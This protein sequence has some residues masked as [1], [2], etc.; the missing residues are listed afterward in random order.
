MSSDIISNETS[1]SATPSASTG[2]AVSGRYRGTHFPWSDKLQKTARKVWGFH[3]FRPLQLPILNAV[4]SNETVFIMMPSL[5]GKS[6]CY[7]LPA[8]LQPGV[9]LVLSPYY[10]LIYDQFLDLARLGIKPILLTNSGTFSDLA[11]SRSRF[12]QLIKKNLPKRRKLKVKSESPHVPS[13]LVY[14]TLETFGKKLSGVTFLKKLYNLG[15]LNRIVIDECQ[16]ASEQTWDTL[17]GQLAAAEDLYQ[18]SKDVPFTFLTSACSLSAMYEILYKYELPGISARISV[19]PLGH[20]SEEVFHVGSV[21]GEYRRDI[22]L[23]TAPL[24]RPNLAYHVVRRPEE[25]EAARQ[26][27]IQW[28]Q[29]YHTGQCGLIFCHLRDETEFLA[30]QLSENNIRAEPYHGQMHH[31]RRQGAHRRWR[32]EETHVLVSTVAFGRGIAHPHV[33]FVIHP[34]LSCTLESYYYESGRAG[35]DGAPA[36]CV[37]FHQMQDAKTLARWYGG[38]NYAPYSSLSGPLAF[39]DNVSRC[40]QLSLDDYL[41][42]QTHSFYIN[43]PHFAD[44]VWSY[45]QYITE[46]RTKGLDFLGNFPPEH[47]DRV[48]QPLEPASQKPP[49]GVDTSSP[50]GR[51][52]ICTQRPHYETVDVCEDVKSICVVFR[53]IEAVNTSGITPLILYKAWCKK[54]TKHPEIATAVE[55]N[56][57][58]LAPLQT[59]NRSEC[60]DFLF[61]CIGQ[62]YFTMYT[63]STSYKTIAYISIGSKGQPFVDEFFRRRA[64]IESGEELIKME[65][66]QNPTILYRYC[67]SGENSNTPPE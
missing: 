24:L 17:R 49:L 12:L 67:P 15:V 29:T 64:R 41:V 25:S 57:I 40:R 3:E 43:Q 2:G 19:D 10:A 50:C 8:L 53:L 36:D 47:I 13:Y 48:T 18:Y 20:Y 5:G 14:M 61:W 45:N 28:I 42:G 59:M 34:T 27:L 51:C 16:S 55:R 22:I 56:L 46:Y 38:Q 33:R 66:V 52:D 31:D 23:F 32:E 9:T 39:V 26:Q 54:Y 4:M 65:S 37:I 44:F 35:G 21:S 58:R 30:R 60:Q 1:Q 7:Q 63:K 6:L 62:E 11:I